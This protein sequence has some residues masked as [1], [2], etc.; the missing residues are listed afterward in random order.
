[1]ARTSR[2][3]IGLTGGIGSGKSAAADRFAQH[4]IAVV[5]TDDISRELTGAN[6]AAMPAIKRQFGDAFLTP[7]G[8]LNREAMRQ[9]VFS[10]P[11][12]KKQLEAILHPLIRAE[13]LK[14]IA[15]ATSPYVILAVPL[16]FETGGYGEIV[17]STLVVD[18]SELLQIER[19][20]QRSGMTGEQV[21]AV[22]AA[23]LTRKARL[24]N[25]DDVIHNNGTLRELADEVD[26]LHKKYLAQ[27]NHLPR[28]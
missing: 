11:L 16:L 3:V 12:A 6:G 25:A 20:M 4:G 14:R 10:D 22:M 8:A 27:S 1:M 15:A 26:R 2:L 5:D 17:S 21:R 18:C 28:A 13:S 19:T 9:R 23:Q 24:K 7:I